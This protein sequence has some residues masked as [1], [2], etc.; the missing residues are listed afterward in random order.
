MDSR[1]SAVSGLT[2]RIGRRTPSVAQRRPLLCGGHP[3]SPTDPSGS[4]ARATAGGAETVAVSFDHRQQPACRTRRRACGR[5]RPARRGRC[6]PRRGPSRRERSWW[7]P[8]GILAGTGDK[9]KT[10]QRLDA[11]SRWCA[12]SA[13]VPLG[14]RPDPRTLR[15][16]LVEEVLELDHALGEGEPQAIRGEVSDLLLHLAFQLVIAEE[17]DEFTAD[18]VAAELERKMRRRH[19]HLFDLGDAEP[20]E[21]IKRRERRGTTLAGIVPTLPP[22]LMA[23]R[24]QE[25]AASVGFDWPDV[26]GPMEKVREELAEVEAG[27]GIRPARVRPAD[28]RDRRPAVRGRQPGAEG[29]RPARAGARPGQP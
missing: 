20:W 23:Y 14:P 2:T 10:I 19:P 7:K 3:D 4:R 17:R 28:G 16:Y 21:R 29:G 1:V 27:A 11:R 13:A 24:L 25:R 15:P 12:T 9:C 8:A 5:W 18:E 26:E 22:L 6:R